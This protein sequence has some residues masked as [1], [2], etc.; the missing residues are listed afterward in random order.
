[1][2]DTTN[3]LTEQAHTPER[4]PHGRLKAL[5]SKYTEEHGL[6]P[7]AVIAEALDCDTNYVRTIAARCNISL[8]PGAATGGGVAWAKIKAENERLTEQ[9]DALA[10]A[11]TKALVAID[12]ISCSGAVMEAVYAMRAALAKARETGA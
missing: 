9:R 1:M 8:P 6:Q 11:T 10:K 12:T 2:T 3:K 4:A 5:F 7:A